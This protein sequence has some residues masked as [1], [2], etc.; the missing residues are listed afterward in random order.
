MFSEEDM[1]KR[2]IIIRR[3]TGASLFLIGSFLVIRYFFQQSFSDVGLTGNNTLKS[4]LWALPVSFAAVIVNYYD[5]RKPGN[6][7]IYPQIRLTDWNRKIVIVSALGWIGYLLG[8]E[9]MFRGFLLH[10]CLDSF[11]Y[12]PAILI[13][14]TLYALAHIPKGPK[15]IYGSF[16][17]G[18]LLCFGTIQLGSLLFAILVHISLALSNEW[19]SLTYHPEMRISSRKISDSM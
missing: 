6:L 2:R 5:A 9:F 4:I 16:F 13:N 8:Y 10:A 3:F 12:W 19:F 11:G 17:L 14:M 15:E 7:D 1:A 18:F